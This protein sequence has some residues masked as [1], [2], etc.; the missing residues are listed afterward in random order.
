MAL[1]AKIL[2]IVAWIAAAGVLRAALPGGVSAFMEENCVSCHD[3]DTKKGGLDLDALAFEPADAKIFSEWVKV[4]DRVRD[5][6][7]PPKKKHQP[8]AAETDAFLKTLAEPLTAADRA[9]AASE[10][11]ATWRRLNR[12]E[13]EN[14]LRDLLRAPWLQIKETLPEDGE[15]FRFNKVGDALDVSHVQMARYLGAADDALR[16]VMAHGIA[17]PETKVVRYYAREQ[18]A[19]AAKV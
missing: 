6:E 2:T 18:R 19:F 16:Q 9:R 8:A 5:R 13:Y 14:T 7:M 17:R 11:R 3:A 4:F 12:F 15:A 1:N 10:G